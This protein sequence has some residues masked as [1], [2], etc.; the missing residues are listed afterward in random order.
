MELICQGSVSPEGIKVLMSS[1]HLPRRAVTTRTLTIFPSAPSC[2][3]HNPNTIQNCHLLGG[4][5][6]LP[7]NW[8]PLSEDLAGHGRRPLCLSLLS[9]SRPHPRAPLPAPVLCTRL[10]LQAAKS[11]P[12][13]SILLEPGILPSG[14]PS[15]LTCR[16]FHFKV[17]LQRHGPP[18][19]Q[20]GL[21]G[22][23]SRKNM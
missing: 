2:L 6:A 12:L 14:L 3:P 5:Q 8:V 22:A 16:L 21:L 4:T 20:G 23:Q 18:Q 17:W 15:R 7:G 10:A 1:T 11:S 19:R 13:Q 9:N